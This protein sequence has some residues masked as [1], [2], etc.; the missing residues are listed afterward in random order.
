MSPWGSLL[1]H[2]P[3][4]GGNAAFPVQPL[5]R[6][7]IHNQGG[8]TGFFKLPQQFIV[9]LPL[10]LGHHQNSLM[11]QCL[12]HRIITAF[13]AHTNLHQPKGCTEGNSNTH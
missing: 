4:H 3:G 2:I 10:P 12:F 7:V 8:H 1:Q 11:I 5:Q 9:V 6:G 13:N